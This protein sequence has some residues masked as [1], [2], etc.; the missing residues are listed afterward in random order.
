MIIQN[1]YLYRIINLKVSAFLC[2]AFLCIFLLAIPSIALASGDSNKVYEIG[3]FPHLSKTHL[4]QTYES[5]IKNISE[6]TDHK[7]HFDVDESIENFYSHLK[8][9]HYDIVMLQPFE[10][11][12]LAKKYGYRPLASQIHP[13]KALIVSKK[14]GAIQNIQNLL[15]RK[16]LLP[17]DS[18]AI[19]YLTKKHLHDFGFDLN[20]DLSIRYERT[21]IACLQKLLLGFTDA[22]ATLQAALDFFEKRMEVKFQVITQSIEIPHTLFAVHPRVDAD[23]REMLAKALLEW[24]NQPKAGKPASVDLLMPFRRIT[25][26]DYDIVRKIKAE[27]DTY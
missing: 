16:L 10:Y 3:I 7:I 15:G 17:P 4:Q 21:H 14:G 6:N 9:E 26:K 25:D 12:E 19:S 11:V 5:V 24:R 13:L 1:K 18:T 2:V 20:Q 22:C 23:H 27:V 8:S